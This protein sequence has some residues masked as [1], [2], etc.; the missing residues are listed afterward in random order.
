[1]GTIKETPEYVQ[2]MALVPS[3]AYEDKDSECPL[4]KFEEIEQLQSGAFTGELCYY[5]EYDVEF[6][7]TWKVPP[8]IFKVLLNKNI[9]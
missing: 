8:I 7:R 1:M 4:N 5:D 3:Y 9:R 2:L 6:E